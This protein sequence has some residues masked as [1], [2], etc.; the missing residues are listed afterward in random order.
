MKINA[1]VNIELNE[2]QKDELL[3]QLLKE[4][5]VNHTESKLAEND[6]EVSSA[7]KVL[8]HNFM[9]PQEYKDYF[10]EAYV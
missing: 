1:T 6:E 4:V 10:N 3:V 7:A 2:D 9:Y 5:Y 8:L